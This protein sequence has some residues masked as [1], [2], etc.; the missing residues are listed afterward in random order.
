MFYAG[1][2]KTELLHTYIW[3]IKC[4]SCQQESEHELLIT[5]DAL[6]FG[7]FYP[8]KWW[9]RNKE[10]YLKCKNCGRTSVVDENNLNLPP[11][12][13]NYYNQTKIPFAYKL[14]TLVIFPS[15]L[16]IGYFFAFKIFST[17]MS[18]MQPAEK[19]LPG[20]WQDDY[21]V[22]TVYFFD[23]KQYTAISYDSIMFGKY[24]LEGESFR[25][26]L[27][28][29][30]NELPKRNLVKMPLTDHRN[31]EYT[32][33]K[34]NDYEKFQEVYRH[35]LNLWRNKPTKPQSDEELRKRVLDYFN[36]ER[37]KFKIGDEEDVPF[38]DSDVNGPVVFAANG[39]QVSGRSAEKWRYLFYNDTDWE[40]ANEILLEEF[41]KEF[42]GDPNE[43]NLFDQ[44]VR[45]L[46]LYIQKV[47]G[48]DLKFLE[49]LSKNKRL[50]QKT[51]S[52][53]ARFR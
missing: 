47:K 51:V 13:I 8:L 16:L 21:Q 45:F 36:F 43:Q 15:L 31:G 23:D 49:K 39:Y 10:G 52:F 26:S 37:E 1:L 19:K 50:S 22:Y 34:K 2:R 25:M 48:S 12:V 35:N 40:R 3:D 18:V 27:F 24:S 29:T 32:L 14:P 42:K 53:F 11:K 28:G 33:V 6:C 38:I 9:A 5:C 41:P 20:K 46:N 4:N 44:N 30:E 7:I 17:V